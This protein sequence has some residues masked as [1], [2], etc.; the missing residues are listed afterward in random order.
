MNPR[1]KQIL[2]SKIKLHDIHYSIYAGYLTPVEIRYLVDQGCQTSEGCKWA[3][4]LAQQDIKQGDGISRW[5]YFTPSEGIL[6]KLR[7]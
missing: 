7:T 3:A 6:K 2:L 1:N 5:F 4:D